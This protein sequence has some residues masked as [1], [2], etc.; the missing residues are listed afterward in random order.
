MRPTR[1][2][3]AL[4][5]LIFG[6]SGAHAFGPLIE[7]DQLTAESPDLIIDIRGRAAFEEGHL[8]GAQHAAYGLWRGPSDNPGRV[9]DEAALEA[10]LGSIG[11]APDQRVLIVHEGKNQTNFG[12][13]ARVY[14]TLKTAGFTELAILNGGYR[15]W[16][17]TGTP[18]VGAAEPADAVVDITLSDEWWIDADG[19]AAVV[20]GS[21]PAVL[22]D[23][24]PAAFFEGERKHDEAAEAG[25][26]AGALNIV[27]STWFGSDTPRLDAPPEKIE[28]IRALAAEAGGAPIV[29]F[30]N[31]GHWAATNWFAVSEI[32]G[33]EG[34][35]LYPESMVGWTRLG[36][37]VTLGGG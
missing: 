5:L 31:T 26:L 27:H 3:L 6:A 4:A 37:A 25:T 9:P 18:E 17:E 13:A 14:W 12:S 8:P 16:A 28:E 23:A 2:F 20:A 15:A 24:R 19:V 10:L 32:A 34:V 1:P 33:V 36:G 7:P 35:K 11:A 30:C 22:I 21:S 29:S